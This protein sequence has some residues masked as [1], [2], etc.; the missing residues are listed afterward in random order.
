MASGPPAI[1]VV[2]PPMLVAAET[3]NPSTSLSKKLLPAPVVVKPAKLLTSFNRPKV[4]VLEVLPVKAL[5]T[6]AV[7]AF[8]VTAPVI[9]A[10]PSTTVPKVAVISP[11]AT[12]V[13]SRTVTAL[14]VALVVVSSPSKLIAPAVPSTKMVPAAAL[15]IDA[16]S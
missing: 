4:T 15:T 2:V 3:V 8:C 7:P 10:T 6:I 16:A 9:S 13:A 1:N 11:S 5:A 14:A 12:V